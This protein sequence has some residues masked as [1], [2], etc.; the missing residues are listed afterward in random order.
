MPALRSTATHGAN[1]DDLPHETEDQQRWLLTGDLPCLN[2][3]Y[4]LRGLVGPIVRCPECGHHND[5]RDPSPW[6]QKDLPLGVRQREHWP[7]SAAGCGLLILFAAMLAPALGL[8]FGMLGWGV[9][10]LLVLG[11]IVV[12]F[13][14]CRRFIR[15]ARS[16]RWAVLLL[17]ATHLAPALTFAGMLGWIVLLAAITD[18]YSLYSKPPAIGFGLLLPVGLLMFWRIKVHLKR[19]DSHAAFRTD[20]RNYRIP[21]QTAPLPEDHPGGG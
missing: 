21:T 12:W 11:C 10:G 6:R 5:L 8:T 15:S 14:K 17:I 2:D 4:N 7:A 20:W 16:T 1:I 3:G 9:G 19:Q 18:P 13:V